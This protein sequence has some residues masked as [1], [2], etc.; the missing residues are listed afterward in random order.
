[1]RVI[2]LPYLSI[3]DVLSDART[4]ISGNRWHAMFIPAS[5]KHGMDG[6]LCQTSRPSCK[7]SYSLYFLLFPIDADAPPGPS[8][9]SHSDADTLL[10]LINRLVALEACWV[11]FARGCN[12]ACRSGQMVINI[13]TRP[14]LCVPAS[15]HAANYVTVLLSQNGPLAF[16]MLNAAAAAARG[17]SLLAM[18]D[19]EC[20][21]AVRHSIDGFKLSLNYTP[22]LAAQRMA[23]TMGYQTL[24]QHMILASCQTALYAILC[25]SP[26]CPFVHSAASKE[27]FP[28]SR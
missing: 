1:M 19:Q 27:H 20:A 23:G 21:W 24:A 9:T 28:A 26:I 16:A 12:V 13:D 6:T 17:I 11:P 2:V 15:F 3:D 18:G 5:S 4:G 7:R 10:T 8:T 14:S 25:E 22:G